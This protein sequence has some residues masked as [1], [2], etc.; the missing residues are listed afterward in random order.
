M[1]KQP[2]FTLGHLDTLV[3]AD[4]GLPIR[5]ETLRIDLALTQ[6]IPGAI[7][8]LKVVLKILTPRR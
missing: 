1:K 4:E 5:A 3:I 8:T 6:D 2:C 7:Q